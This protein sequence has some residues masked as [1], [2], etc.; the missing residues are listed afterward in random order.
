[1]NDTPP[2]DESIELD[3]DGQTL[4]I[5]ADGE[6]IPEDELGYPVKLAGVSHEYEEQERRSWNLVVVMGSLLGVA[7]LMILCAWIYNP[8]SPTSLAADASP[9]IAATR[10]SIAS[11]QASD[12]TSTREAVTAATERA[13]TMAA[14]L[15][16]QIAQQ[17]DAIP[18]CDSTQ[19]AVGML[20]F[21]AERLYTGDQVV[22]RQAVDRSSVCKLLDS[23]L[24]YTVTR[25]DPDG[26]GAVLGSSETGRYFHA[27]FI[28]GDWVFDSTVEYNVN[29]SIESRSPDGTMKLDLYFDRWWI[30]PDQGASFPVHQPVGVSNM[31]WVQW[32]TLEDR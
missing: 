8:A 14:A 17:F 26:L 27:R 21:V 13:P 2:Q 3:I 28:G 5:G 22:L 29:D 12:A 23:P 19:S 4:R 6:L 7:V 9:Y 16:T 25:F 1:M 31:L 20:V 30:F 10:T 32:V 15:R 24:L 18:P 11:T